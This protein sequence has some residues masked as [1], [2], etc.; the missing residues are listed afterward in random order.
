MNTWMCTIIMT[1]FGGPGDENTSAYDGTRIDPYEPSV[2]LPYHF[3]IMPRYVE[4]RRKVTAVDQNYVSVI[5]RVRDVGPHFVND[6]YWAYTPPQRP[7]A[8]HAY[9][10]HAGLDGTRAVHDALKV[11]GPKGE[12]TTIVD[13]R[14]MEHLVHG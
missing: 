5:A 14:M 2:A 6:P 7:R 12:R 13:W 3:H 10:N 8:E 1:E 9:G 4:I 11:K